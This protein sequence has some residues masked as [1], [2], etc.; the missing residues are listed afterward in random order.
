MVEDDV[1]EEDVLFQACT[2]LYLET[3]TSACPSVPRRASP[4]YSLATGTRGTFPLYLS[5]LLSSYRGLSCHPSRAR[6]AAH[7]VRRGSL[8]A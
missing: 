4:L 6:T 5:S 8:T 1:L 7:I 3:D 2:S